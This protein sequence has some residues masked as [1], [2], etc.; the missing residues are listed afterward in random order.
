MIGSL[1]IR[2]RRS[3]ER[4]ITGQSLQGRLALLT[5]VS[6]AL[7][8]LFVGTTAYVITRISLMDQLDRELL[9]TAASAAELVAADPDNR[10]AEY[11]VAIRSYLKGRGLG[12][13][14]MQH[15]I[16]YA[17]AEGLAFVHPFDDPDVI[18]W[19]S[20]PSAIPTIPASCGW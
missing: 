16:S 10:T 7:A 9:T 15:L 18:A 13:Q 19:A 11:A 17:R 2:L 6:V 14:L 4:L 3:G 8:V 5:G 12:W 20:R 1:W